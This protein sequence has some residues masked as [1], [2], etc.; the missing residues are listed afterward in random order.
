MKSRMYWGVAILILLLVT[1]AVFVILR[2]IADNRELNDQLTEAQKLADQITQRK[3]SENNKKSE[4]DI[5]LEPKDTD[6]DNFTVEV[7]N[8][9]DAETQKQSEE[10]KDVHASVQTTEPKDVQVSPFGFGPYPEV[11]EGMLDSVGNPYKPAWERSYWSDRPR[12]GAELLSRVLIKAWKEGTRD[13][14]GASGGNNGKVW[15]NYPNTLYIQYGEPETR[16]DG[17]IYRPIVR[18][19]GDPSVRLTPDEMANGIVPAGVRVLDLD[20]DAINIFEYLNLS[21][22]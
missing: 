1:A 18:A 3:I 19:K 4:L 15:I 12:E 5:P 7:G 16:S 21:K 9:T 13:W 17:T 10:P 2:E 6:S 8:N 22:K 11:P 14:I 20:A